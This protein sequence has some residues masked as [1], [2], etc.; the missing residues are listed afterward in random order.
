MEET[1]E[2]KL[3]REYITLVTIQTEEGSRKM[4]AF[5]GM[6]YPETGAQVIG[7]NTSGMCVESATL[8][9]DT[10]VYTV[11]MKAN[12]VDQGREIWERR[13]PQEEAD[14]KHLD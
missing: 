7:E 6:L 11:L 13:W 9:R 8:S 5:P 12:A 1:L 10:D 14:G 2:E 4:V 3:N